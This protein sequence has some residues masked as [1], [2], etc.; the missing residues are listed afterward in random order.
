M[1]HPDDPE[2]ACGGTI[3]LWTRTDAVYYILISSGD[4]GT[5]IR[6]DSPYKIAALREQEAWRAARYLG[7]RKVIFMRRS[8]GDIACSDMLK[9]EL[10]MLIRHLRPDTIVTHDPWRRQFHSDHR[11]TGF[12]VIDAVMIARDWHFSPAMMEI[13]LRKHRARELL[14]TPTDTPTLFHDI[15]LT[16]RRKIAATRKHKSQLTTLY[17]WEQRIIE[18]ARNEG[19]SAGYAY[20]EGFYWM[21]I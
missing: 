20:A 1:A 14:L 15:T 12:A 21:R 11:A 7:V 16:L 13:G 9:L 18:R 4:K 5:W 19:I 17:R 8:D 2:L 6:T 10:A 3:A